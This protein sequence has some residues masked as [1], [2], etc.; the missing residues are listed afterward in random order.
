M[1]ANA[2]GN[3][4]WGPRQRKHTTEQF[5]LEKNNPG[6]GYSYQAQDLTSD[7]LQSLWASDPL[8]NITSNRTFNTN[9]RNWAARF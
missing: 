4:R 3:E 1:A 7:Y 9:F 2:G 6:S 8:Y 5:E